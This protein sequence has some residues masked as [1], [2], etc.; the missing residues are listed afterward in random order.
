MAKTFGVTQL[1]AVEETVNEVA[2]ALIHIGFVVGEH[3]D[4]Q[5][6]DGTPMKDLSGALD[7]LLTA[8]RGL[9]SAIGLLR[10]YEM[11]RQARAVSA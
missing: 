1:Y 10:A 11:H 9:A 7:R 5:N 2:D 4:E 3:A 8:E 6:W